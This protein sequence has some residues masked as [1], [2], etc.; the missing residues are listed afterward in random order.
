MN[1]TRW[2]G[3]LVYSIE[4]D[5]RVYFDFLRDR[6]DRGS[7]GAPIDQNTVKLGIEYSFENSQGMAQRTGLAGR[8]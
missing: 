5:V 3:G 8:R 2:G 1:R 4:R 7:L 6:L